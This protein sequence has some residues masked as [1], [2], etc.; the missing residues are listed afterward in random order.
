M[1]GKHTTVKYFG[2]MEGTFRIILINI[3][4]ISSH[5]PKIITMTCGIQIVSARS[6]TSCVKEYM[7]H[8]KPQAEVKETFS[9][10]VFGRIQRKSEM[11]L[12]TTYYYVQK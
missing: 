6:Q 3:M 11:T 10:W 9:W 8:V 5:I 1:S 4:K 2:D 12:E 7:S